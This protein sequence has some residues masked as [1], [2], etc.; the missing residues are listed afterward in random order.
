M[1]YSLLHALQPKTIYDV[2]SK[3]GA[4]SKRFR[5]LCRAADIVAFEANPD[6]LAAMHRDP[7]FVRLAIAI[8][9]DA[10]SN[11][12]GSRTFFIPDHQ[13]PQDPMSGASSLVALLPGKTGRNVE[14]STTTLEH[15]TAATNSSGSVALW[16]DVEGHA[17]EVLDGAV[18][19]LDRVAFLHVEVEDDPLF[20]DQ[21]VFT[22]VD[23]MVRERGFVVFCRPRNVDRSWPQYNVVYVRRSVLEAFSIVARV[24]FELALMTLSALYPGYMLLRRLLRTY[25]ARA[26]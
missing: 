1:F 17:Y 5:S 8:C 26:K 11:V 10:V 9:G 22:E 4:N 3:D 15:Y 23:G 2:G 24:K 21:H 19:L 16:I 12:R 18:T 20:G 25:F 13:G 14:V 7:D 6:N